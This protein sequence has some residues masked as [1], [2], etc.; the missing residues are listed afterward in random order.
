MAYTVYRG[1]SLTKDE[2]ASFAVDLVERRRIHIDS[3]D[4]TYLTEE[5]INHVYTFGQ[6]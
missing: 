6:L 5:V 2:T 3:A 1:R 4:T